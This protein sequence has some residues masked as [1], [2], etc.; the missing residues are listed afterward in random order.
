MVF[1]RKLCFVCWQNTSLDKFKTASKL[2]NE[3]QIVTRENMFYNS[4]DKQNN[5]VRPLNQC[6][7]LMKSVVK[8]KTNIM[9]TA[10][11][12]VIQ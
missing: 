6:P 3:L 4:K 2:K 11:C 1:L 7:L 5:E 8:Y 12:T 10:Y 9:T